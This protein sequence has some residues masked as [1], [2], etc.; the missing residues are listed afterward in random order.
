[1]LNDESLAAIFQ[2]FDFDRW[3]GT[4]ALGR[5][6][7]VRNYRIPAPA[8]G[9]DLVRAWT[10]PS[11]EG[12]PPALQ[13]IWRN[14][15]AGPDAL[16]RVDMYECASRVAAH[17]FMVRLLAE[18]QVGGVSRVAQGG[19][20]D[21]H[22]TAGAGATAVF[23]RG[24]LV[25]FV[26]RAG[27]HGAPATQ[28]IAATIDADIVAEPP[29]AAAFAPSAP[30]TAKAAAA[31]PKAGD[32]IPLDIPPEVAG[33]PAMVKVFTDGGEVSNESGRLELIVDDPQ[34]AAAHVYALP[35][36]GGPSRHG[37]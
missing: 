7:Y 15:A 26:T 20:G 10:V 23:A 34:T 12:S 11:V 2:R 30:E 5:G 8:P 21:V 32:R 9:W 29:T 14:P 24:N 16:L 19:I 36:E 3:K 18:H 28:P 37:S 17:E 4:N 33:Q 25:I 35:A 6:L 22:A 1:M 13:T 31:P 27:R